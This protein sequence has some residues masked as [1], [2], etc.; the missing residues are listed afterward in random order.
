[1]TNDHIV[2]IYENMRKD[3]QY[4]K[5]IDF[6][7]VIRVFGQA[8]DANRYREALEECKYADDW[9]YVLKIAREALKGDK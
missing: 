2:E 5:E 7:D 3:F 1:M 8:K 9:R 4:T 6:K